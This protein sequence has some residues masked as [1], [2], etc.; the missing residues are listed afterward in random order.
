MTRAL[1]KRRFDAKI[2]R[3]S[4]QCVSGFIY[5]GGEKLLNFAVADERRSLS[6][7]GG[8][9]KNEI[10]YPPSGWDGRQQNA[11]LLGVF[12]IIDASLTGCVDQNSPSTRVRQRN[13][14]CMQL[15]PDLQNRKED[16]FK[17][18]CRKFHLIASASDFE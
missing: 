5:K 17:Q 8:L 1:L 4:A 13:Q 10:I 18:K 15:R 9:V 14:S 6:G 3:W 11:L 16:P 2:P 12:V 7:S